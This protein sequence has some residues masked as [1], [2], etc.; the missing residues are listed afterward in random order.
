LDSSVIGVGGS[1][2]GATVQRIAAM[3]SWMMYGSR[4]KTGVRQ[5]AS[6]GSFVQTIENPQ[7][8]LMPQPY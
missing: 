4:N 2:R 8:K 1:A 5:P 7:Q 6:S 3:P